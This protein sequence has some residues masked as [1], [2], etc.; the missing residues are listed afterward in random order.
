MIII[1]IQKERDA[2]VLIAS[3]HNFPALCNYVSLEH[4]YDSRIQLTLHVSCV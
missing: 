1:I 2:D 3:Q 4:I